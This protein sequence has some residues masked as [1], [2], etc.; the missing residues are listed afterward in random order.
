MARPSPT[1]AGNP[2][3]VALG[4]AIRTARKEKGLSQEA[5]AIEAGVDRSFMGGVERGQHNLTV[6]S[7]IK[8]AHRLGIDPHKLLK[9]SGL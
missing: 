4:E 7:L 2:A 1:H 5:L 9:D 6:I 8:I 3:L